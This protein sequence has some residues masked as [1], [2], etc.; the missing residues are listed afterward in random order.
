MKR[1]AMLPSTLLTL[2]LFAGRLPAGVLISATEKSLPDG[3]AS[4]T[5]IQVEPD[6]IRV[7]TTA[8]GRKQVVIFRGDRQLLWTIDPEQKTYY[9]ITKAELEQLVSQMENA[10]SAIQQQMEERLKSMPPEQRAA[11]EQVMKNRGAVLGSKVSVAKTTYKKVAA[12]EKIRQWSCDKYEGYRGDQ[13]TAE[14]WTADWNQLGLGAEDFQALQ[15]MSKFLEGMRSSISDS[16]FKVGGADWQEQQAY[17][18][19]P[20][21]RISYRRAGAYRESEVQE[22]RKETLAAKLFELDPGLTKQTFLPP[23]KQRLP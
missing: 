23:G 12:G 9:E 21:R 15:Q 3:A 20:L 18:G 2:A 4:T 1:S 13:I 10:M 14:V 7:D 6:R 22:I 17:P 16:F 11:L 5:T 19:L 8:D